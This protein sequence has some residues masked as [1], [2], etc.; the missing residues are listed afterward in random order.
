ME[1]IPHLFASLCRIAVA[2]AVSLPLSVVLGILAAKGFIAVILKYML[3]VPKPALLPLIM[4]IFGIGEIAKSVLLV[5][6]LVF[7]LAEAVRASFES[8]DQDIVFR[9][10]K[11][12]MTRKLAFTSMYLPHCAPK[13]LD[14]LGNTAAGAFAL[15]ILAESFGTR[16]GLGFYMT[17]CWIKM[18]Y[19]DMLSSVLTASAAGCL[20]PLFF[21]KIKKHICPWK[22][23]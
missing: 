8:I 13:I 2:L 15:L 3:S 7:P 10:K 22:K 12:G 18:K 14:S 23:D 4:L 21:I 6:C 19:A 5:I 17:D 9:Y 16:T 20:F 11:A 1:L